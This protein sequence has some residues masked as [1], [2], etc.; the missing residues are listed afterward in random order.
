MVQ[1]GLSV[2]N[3]STENWAFVHSLEIYSEAL[4]LKEE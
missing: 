3:S 1:S 2:Q 4:F